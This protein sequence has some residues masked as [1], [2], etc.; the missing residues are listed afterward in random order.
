MIFISY[1]V[2]VLV[3]E[4]RDLIRS[5][6]D[7]RQVG[8]SKPRQPDEAAESP[9]DLS[10]NSTHPPDELAHLTID[11]ASCLEQNPIS[12][13]SRGI[14]H[15][16]RAEPQVQKATERYEP[17]E[18]REYNTLIQKLLN[19]L[20]SCRSKLERTRHSRIKDGVFNIHSG[21][22]V[23]F[24]T[25]YGPSIHIDH[26]LF[27]Y[28]PSFAPSSRLTDLDS[29]QKTEI[30]HEANATEFA[31]TATSVRAKARST[32]TSV[33]YNEEFDES[34][35]YDSD[36]STRKQYDRTYPRHVSKGIE[37]SRNSV[38]GYARAR[39]SSSPVRKRDFERD[40]TLAVVARNE[41]VPRALITGADIE[42]RR[43]RGVYERFL[44]GNARRSWQSILASDAGSSDTF[45]HDPDPDAELPVRQEERS[46][47]KRGATRYHVTWATGLQDP[48]IS[49][50][51]SIRPVTMH[52]S[53][54]DLRSWGERHEIERLQCELVLYTQTTADRGV[55]Y[56][57]LL[58]D[59]GT[60]GEDEMS[61]LVRVRGSL[62]YEARPKQQAEYR[63]RLRMLEEANDAA[64]QHEISRYS[65]DD[66]A[67]SDDSSSDVERES[68]DAPEESTVERRGDD[69]QEQTF[70]DLSL[71]DNLEDLLTQWTTLD[72]QEIQRGRVEAF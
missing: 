68:E 48:S 39:R 32:G 59:G 57:R 62:N 21:E 16:R 26:S 38:Q 45:R 44:D 6:L 27:R 19:E 22:I 64:A 34:D 63:G 20:E 55:S 30:I 46:I 54:W 58:Q 25:E 8:S 37:I 53:R 17:P 69:D 14:T 42:R 52:D 51:F 61:A 11:G 5:L 4:Q 9:R 29:E 36:M 3:Q 10:T 66:T 56:L 33:V 1:N 47:V 71:P 65:L 50:T 72:K 2:P 60:Q 12:R 23:R 31:H 49:L 40:E 67:G 7:D 28:V 70:S 43:I 35:L 24:K 18:L 15:G 13:N 41:R